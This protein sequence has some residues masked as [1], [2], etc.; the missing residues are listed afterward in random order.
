[1]YVHYTSLIMNNSVVVYFS[2]GLIPIH[3]YQLANLYMNVCSWLSLYFPNDKQPCCC[4]FSGGLIPIHKY[5]L[6]LHKIT[7]SKVN[8]EIFVN[9]SIAYL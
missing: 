9:D 4:L 3:N 2:G 5:K 6:E 7:L 8:L 1:M